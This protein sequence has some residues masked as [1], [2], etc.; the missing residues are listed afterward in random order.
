MRVSIELIKKIREQSGAGISDVREALEEAQGNETKALEIL[1]KKGQKFAAKRSER[2]T[3]E[4]LIE[5][6][7]SDDRKRGTIVAVACETDFVSRNKDFKQFVSK[8]LRE[9]DQNG[10]D[11]VESLVQEA[12]AK[13]DENIVFKN[14]TTLTIN[15]GLIESYIHSNGKVGVLVSVAAASDNVIK[16]GELRNFAHE[17]ALQVAATNPQYLKPELIPQEVI[18][19]EKEIYR[20][21]LKQEGKPANII[22]KIIEGKLQKFYSEVCLFKQPY[23]RDDKTTIE[24]LLAQVQDKVGGQIEIKDFVRLSL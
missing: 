12:I 20:E 21:Q 11:R 2:A 8:V 1:R 17:I 4:G 15:Q 10:P 6:K 22:D 23:I 24:R 5:V 18:K 13:I 16:S 7:L 3:N 19:K 14:S 9:V